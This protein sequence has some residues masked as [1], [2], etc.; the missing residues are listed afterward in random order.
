MTCH[1]NAGERMFW[2]AAEHH[3]LLAGV[4]EIRVGRRVA[5]THT[6]HQSTLL[7]NN[8]TSRLKQRPTAV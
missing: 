6:T 2:R 8:Q 4:G 3:K 5:I 1:C 7:R